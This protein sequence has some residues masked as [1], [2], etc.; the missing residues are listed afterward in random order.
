MSAE[1][2]HILKTKVQRWAEAITAAHGDSVAAI[3]AVGEQL[4]RAKADCSHGEWGELTGRTTGKPLLPFSFQT[5][6]RFQTIAA[7]AALSNVAHGRHLPASWRTLAALASLDPD[8]IE[9]AIADGAIH[10]EMERKDAESLVAKLK[11]PPPQTEIPFLQPQ[12]EASP[13]AATPSALDQAPAA[14]PAIAAQHEAAKQVANDKL[15]ELVDLK[16]QAAAAREA[17]AAADRDDTMLAW[18]RVGVDVSVALEGA[19]M[20]IDWARGHHPQARIGTTQ[21]EKIK[22][23]VQQLQQFIEEIEHASNH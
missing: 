22:A 20:R 15:Q 1:N 23:S 2:V 14:E 17:N 9:A 7:N 12:P 19:L 8:D 16:Q 18:F 6:H 4:K 21:L 10:P 3:I 13:P 11:R 5:A